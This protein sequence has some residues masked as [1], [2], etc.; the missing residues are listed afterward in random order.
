MDRILVSACLIGWPVR[1]DGTAKPVGGELLALWAEEGRLVPVCP[2]TMAGLPT[3]RPAVEIARGATAADVLAGRAEVVDADGGIWSAEMREGARIALATARARGCRFALLAEGSPSCG[4]SAIADGG[5]SGTR[6][7]G[8]G[9]T[10]R[11]LRDAG[12]AV[13]APAEIERL[14]ARLDREG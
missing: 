14:A 9:L 10:T 12:I 11:L 7:P 1:W 6:I 4:S 2:E 8:E 5:F 13:F 3:P